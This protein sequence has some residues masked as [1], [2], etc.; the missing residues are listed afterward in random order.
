MSE[1]PGT[2]A[3]WWA[4]M[5]RRERDLRRCHNT[6]TPCHTDRA[7][8]APAPRRHIRTLSLPQSLSSSWL[9]SGGLNSSSRPMVLRPRERGVVAGAASSASSLTC[10][11]MEAARG[12]TRRR[13]SGDYSLSIPPA[14]RGSSLSRCLMPAGM[15]SPAQNGSSSCSSETGTHG[16]M[17][18]IPSFLHGA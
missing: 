7:S 8:L 11:A 15:P 16:L 10:S 6:M 9:W 13:R 4:R 5:H 1:L 3:R 17:S 2:S 12:S 14:S 18:F